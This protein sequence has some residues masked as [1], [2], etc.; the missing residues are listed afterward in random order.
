MR[1]RE[2]EREERAAHRLTGSAHAALF[3]MKRVV[4]SITVPTILRL[5]ARSDEP[6]SVMSTMPST[7]LPFA[8]TSVVPHEYSTLTLTP[9]SLKKRSV[10]I[11]SSVATVMPSMSFADCTGESSGTA[12][13]QRAGRDVA[14]LYLS[15]ATSTTA[16]SSLTSNAVCEQQREC[17]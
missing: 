11:G 1:V 4:D 12:T 5:F 10:V 13:T 3:A 6:V 15:S 7:S 16:S 9:A 8:F 2:R 17:V 14:L